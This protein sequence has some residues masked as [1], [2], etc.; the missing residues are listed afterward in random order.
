MLSPDLL[1][2]LGVAQQRAGE[3]PAAI[4]SYR[5]CL[6]LNPALAEVHNNLGTTLDAAGRFGEALLSF[7]RALA[8]KPDYVRAL[9]NLGKGLQRLERSAEAIR[10]LERALELS[11]DYVPALVNL[12]FAL[13]DAGRPDEALAP[14]RRALAL[15]PRFS[16]AHHGLARALLGAGDAAG[17]FQS[18]ERA[19]ALEPRLTDAHL[20]RGRA[21]VQSGQSAQAIACLKRLA[22]AAPD[23][24]DVH[25]NLAFA[26]YEAG[27]FG[28]ALASANRALALDPQH[29]RAELRRAQALAQLRRH[30][31]ARVSLRRVLARR[32]G[33]SEALAEELNCC[34]RIC[35]WAGVEAALAGIHGL[36][37]GTDAVH[38]FVLMA[39]SDDP[40]LLLRSARSVAASAAQARAPLPAPARHSHERI[41]V[42]YL[43][44]DYCVHAT[45]FLV[46]ELLE[47]HERAQFEVYGVSFGPDDESP[48]R[49]RMIAACDVFADVGERSDLE[50]A[51]WLR[52][53]EI[54]IAVDLKGYT[55]FGRSGILVYRP[56]PIQVNYLGYPGTLGGSFADYLIADAFLVPEAERA[57]YQEQV[58]HLP[59]SY[60]VNDRRRVTA[61]PGPTRAEA[62]LPA[63]AF[64]FCCFNNNWK[65]TAPVFEVWM[66]LLGAVEGSVLWLFEDSEPAAA[67]L[68]AAA[69]ERGIAAGRLVFAT[70]I[71]NDVHLARHRLADLFLDT[72]PVNAHTT[73]SDALWSGLPLVTCAGRAFAAR[74]AGS[75]LR[76]VGLPEL[77]AS[78]LAEYEQLALG[79]ARDPARLVALRRHLLE[80]RQE[81]PL[82]DTPLFCRHLEAAYRQMW[83]T[84]QQGRPPATFKVG[85]DLS[86]AGP[87]DH[88]GA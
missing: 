33:E 11:P 63:D 75:L 57:H 6:R 35:D 9:T 12:G 14:L 67:N 83:A 72:V 30:A 87:G 60:Q 62:G 13:T 44:A 24:A 1:F 37:A 55:A 77:I 71:P 27:Q 53:Q 40:A 76:A 88:A 66:R 49:R 78:S 36:E 38:P 21:L 61:V 80:K 39:V 41:R 65:I 29:W 56:A 20:L 59:N 84:H 10:V 28:A 42:A 18:L 51:R 45:S 17:G 64:V 25:D 16:A 82:F 23:C 3:L 31:E 22:H 70:R 69:M 15:D 2:R 26:L 4:E 47:V 5:Q 46:A 43:S 74:V 85:T 58:V 32:P 79:L 54:D 8:L 73:A 86:I 81:L 50:I 19:L 52:E 34:L 68:R 7:E 48:V